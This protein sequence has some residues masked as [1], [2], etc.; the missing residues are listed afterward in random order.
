M[1]STTDATDATQSSVHLDAIR[2]AAALVV[3]AGHNSDLYFSSVNGR[4]NEASHAP[5][6]QITRPDLAP[7]K[8]A[9]ITIGNEAVMI[10]FVLSGFLVGGGVIRSLRQN[11]WS[12]KNYLI[13]RMTRLWVVL[14]PALVFGVALDFAGLHLHPLPTSIYAAPPQQSVVHDVAGHL[15]PI[16]ILGNAIFLQGSQVGTAGTNDSLWSLSNEFWYYMAFPII[17]LVFSRKQAPWLRVVYLLSFGAI[18]LLV[19]KNISLLFFV[20]VLGAVVSV[21]PLK[22]PYGIARIIGGTLALSLPIV[23]VVIRRAP[24]SYRAA[25]WAIALYFAIVL[26]LLLHQTHRARNGI[27]QS[28]AGFFS[29]MSY[30][31]YLVHMPVAVFLCAYLNSPWRRW[32]R[33]PGNLAI[34]SG[35]C[36]I[37]ILSG[38][39]FY[40]AF[41]ANTDKVR[42]LLFSDV[43]REKHLPT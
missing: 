5:G 4:P 33:S 23:F 29:R 27:Y 40:L 13:K 42:K 39:V 37:L 32:E 6:S 22:I 1:P 12:W 20:W 16:V 8:K 25:Q 24:I 31:T 43:R 2:G 18:G 9:Q 28:I 38:Y 21:I 15:R 26:Y 7:P 19:G 41:E 35:T 36:L 34:F 30:S 3:L 11:T 17:L 10:F 14:I